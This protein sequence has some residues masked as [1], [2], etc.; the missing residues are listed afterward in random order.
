MLESY[1]VRS[2]SR[3]ATIP[4]WVVDLESFTRWVDSPEFPSHGRI[5]FI[6]RDHLGGPEHG[7]ALHP[8]SW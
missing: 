4:A 2:Q 6:R 5:S 1:S 8:Q 7:T 3:E